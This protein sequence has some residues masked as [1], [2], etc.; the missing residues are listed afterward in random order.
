MKSVKTSTI[1]GFTLIELLVTIS[2]F[3]IL[4]A[5]SVVTFTGVFDTNEIST[6]REIVIAL[7]RK[8]RSSAV[9]NL[10]TSDHG[11][12]IA[13]ASYV[14]FE[15]TSYAT[16][17]TN[18]DETYERAEFVTI[19]GAD[20]IIFARLTGSTTSTSFSLSAYET[21]TTVLINNEGTISWQ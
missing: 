6:E 12:Y 4:V 2:V 21:S 8:A 20:E 17:D 9:N 16:R 3:A 5:L 14:L 10:G 19:T 11:L 13:S 7:L 15:G 1:K 18:E